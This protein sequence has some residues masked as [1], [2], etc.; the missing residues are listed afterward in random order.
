MTTVLAGVPPELVVIA[1]SA[2]PV[3]ELR[4]GIP[5]G[6]LGYHLPVWEVFLLAQLGNAIPVALIYALCDWWVRLM[7]RRRGILHRITD[8][9]LRHTHDKMHGG[10]TKWGLAALVIFVAIPLPGAGAWTGTLG[11][12]LLHLPFKK[13]F[14]YIIL[15][16]LISGTIVTLAVTGGVAAFKVFL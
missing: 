14:P 12:Y 11:A 2:M 5:V 16:N 15:G 1:L 8:A 7:E 6:I 9:V 3:G 4:A 13:A 10:M